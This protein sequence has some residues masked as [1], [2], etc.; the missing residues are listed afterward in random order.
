MC[1]SRKR[2]AERSGCDVDIPAGAFREEGRS[3]ERYGVPDVIKT[4][5]PYKTDSGRKEAT[6]TPANA[7][8]PVDETQPRIKQTEHT[9]V[10]NCVPLADIPVIRG[11]I[12]SARRTGCILRPCRVPSR[13]LLWGDPLRRAVLVVCWLWRER[14]RHWHFGP[15]LRRRAVGCAGVDPQSVSKR[16]TGLRHR[17]TSPLFLTLLALNAIQLFYHPRRL[18]PVQRLRPKE[19]VPR[20]VRNM[21]S[22]SR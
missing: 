16:C 3:A 10:G 15:G 7:L 12:S 9:W 2:N 20:P 8:R 5:F 21:F 1:T 22:R 6:H 19:E 17:T 14:G 13:I 11:A 4:Q 18:L